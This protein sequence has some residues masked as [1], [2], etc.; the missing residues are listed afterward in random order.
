[1]VAMGCI[2]FEDHVLIKEQW[3]C[4]KMNVMS[5]KLKNGKKRH[6]HHKW[7]SFLAKVVSIFKVLEIT[8]T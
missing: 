8:K 6:N 2:N 5:E 1:M 3:A 7:F 4:D